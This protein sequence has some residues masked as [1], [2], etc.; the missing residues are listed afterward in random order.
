MVEVTLAAK[1][2]IDAYSYRPKGTANTGRLSQEGPLMPLSY[3]EG[4]VSAKSHKPQLLSVHKGH[5][6]SLR[7][8]IRNDLRSFRK[9]MSANEDY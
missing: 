3:L 2:P 9:V 1:G 4:R 7:R 5:S 8:P 6:P